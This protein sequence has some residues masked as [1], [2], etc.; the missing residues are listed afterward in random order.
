M[1]TAID[2][3]VLWAVFNDEPSATEWSKTLIDASREGE[4]IVCDVVLAE[5]APA[6][7]SKKQALDTLEQLGI[8]FD[9]L[10]IDA[11]FEAGRIFKTYRQEG[12]PL[13]H[14]IPDFLIGSH[15]ICQSDRLAAVDRGYLRRYF[16]KLKILTP[17]QSLKG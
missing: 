9:G 14:M 17:A 1:I 2:S 4:L 3:S 5:I 11:A 12:G 16:P 10:S 13:I 6:F 7:D 8:R 15:A